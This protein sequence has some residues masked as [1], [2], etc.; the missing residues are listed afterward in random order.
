M[1]A[2]SFQG[3]EVAYSSFSGIWV[4]HEMILLYAYNCYFPFLFPLCGADLCFS[5]ILAFDVL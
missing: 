5:C 4:A 1:I 3:N 2:C